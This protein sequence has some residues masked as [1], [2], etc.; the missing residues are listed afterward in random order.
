MRK[1]YDER[2]TAVTECI[3]GLEKHVEQL[4]ASPD[5]TPSVIHEL[6]TVI[7]DIRAICRQQAMVNP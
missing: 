2:L 5:V 7:A 1:E 6:A 3:D 4:R